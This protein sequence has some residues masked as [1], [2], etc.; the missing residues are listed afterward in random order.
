MPLETTTTIAGLDLNSPLVNEKVREGD[1]HLRLIK[2]VLKNIFPGVGGLG[3]NTP[4]LA[5]ET[6]LNFL[7]GLTSNL[8]AQLASISG[9]PVDR[10]AY[11][12]ADT[13]MSVGQTFL[14]DL[15]NVSTLSFMV[16]T[17][18]KQIYDLSMFFDQV[19]GLTGNGTTLLPNNVAA[20]SNI[21]RSDVAGVNSAPAD[22]LVVSTGGAFTLS[23]GGTPFIIDAKI[24][25]RTKGKMVRALAY[26]TSNTTH[27]PA[28]EMNRWS[29]TTTLWTSLGQAAFPHNVS[30]L[31]LLKRVL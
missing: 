17:G 29:D 22:S 1:D 27:S 15:V 5:K 28:L 6:E 12:G 21:I 8:Q 4:I 11:A 18:D 2:S 20:P 30:G 7:Q 23:R 13:V 10:S 24:C 25:T 31:V 14:W 9:T 19:T 26:T 16:A 3:F